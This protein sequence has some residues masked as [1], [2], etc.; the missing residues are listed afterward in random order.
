MRRATLDYRSREIFTKQSY[1][2]N[3]YASNL[4]RRKMIREYTRHGL[5]RFFVRRLTA[6]FDI[7]GNLWHKSF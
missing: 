3:E 6:L 5:I 1:P 4:I 7:E 2:R